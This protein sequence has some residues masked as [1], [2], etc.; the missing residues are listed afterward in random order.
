MKKRGYGKRKEIKDIRKQNTIIERE[1]GRWG[2]RNE[3]EHKGRE[4]REGCG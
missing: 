1:R 2:G 4:K 3:R